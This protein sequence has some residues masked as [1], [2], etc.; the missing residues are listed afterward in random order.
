VVTITDELRT[1]L[2]NAGA[3]ELSAAAEQFVASGESGD[4]ALLAHLLGELSALARGAIQRDERLYCWI[5]VL[6]SALVRRAGRLT[7]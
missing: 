2:A 6:S 4:P 7:D 5:C 1:V 3:A